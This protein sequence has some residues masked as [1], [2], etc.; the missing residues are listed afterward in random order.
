MVR[1]VLVAA[2]ASLL[3]AMLTVEGL[4]LFI[5]PTVVHCLFILIILVV[6]SVEILAILFTLGIGIFWSW[7]WRSHEVV[8]N[9]V[10]LIFASLFA[11]VVLRAFKLPVEIRCTHNEW[12]QTESNTS[13]SHCSH[14]F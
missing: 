3:K 10:R 9:A 8:H 13:N 5:F 7:R 1:A 11:T 12:E 4:I 6:K 2:G 14:N